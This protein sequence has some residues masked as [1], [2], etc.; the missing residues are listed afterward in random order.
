[1]ASLFTRAGKRCHNGK[2]LTSPQ[3]GTQRGILAQGGVALL[4][5]ACASGGCVPAQEYGPLIASVG[6]P[7]ANHASAPPI[8]SL[9]VLVLVVLVIP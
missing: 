7:V 2:R 8:S 6:T 5:P 1:M 3:K 9:P 4:V